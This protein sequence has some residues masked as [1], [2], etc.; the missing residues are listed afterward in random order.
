MLFVVSQWYVEVSPSTRTVFS[1]CRAASVADWV[2]PAGRTCCVACT[3]LRVVVALRSVRARV[4]FESSGSTAELRH[5]KNP[6]GLVGYRRT[7]GLMKTI[8]GQ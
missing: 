6:C 2:V 1:N 4:T 7:T 3:T 5:S 8:T